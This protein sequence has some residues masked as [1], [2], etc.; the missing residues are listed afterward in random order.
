MDTAY[1]GRLGAAQL[2][3]AGV[4]L[5]M[6]NTA[7]KLFNVPLL[8][9]TTSNVAAAT[10]GA[11]AGRM[12]AGGGGG[13]AQAGAG[14]GQAEAVAA[15]ISSSL[16]VALLVG[17]L[18]VGGWS[19]TGTGTA[20]SEQVQTP[21]IVGASPAALACAAARRANPN[22]ESASLQ[23]GGIAGGPG[24]GHRPGGRAAVGGGTRLALARAYAAVSGHAGPGRPGNSHATGAAGEVWTR[25]ERDWRL[26]GLGSSAG[27]PVVLLAYSQDGRIHTDTTTRSSTR[28][29]RNPHVHAS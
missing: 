16:A 25:G 17:G 10:G 11:Q 28:T 4:A 24:V 27:T 21:G 7:S 12:Q 26:R 22:M 19:D 2:A 8:S 20:C 13:G 14:A 23:P 1:I 5:S 15:A 6:F 9:V 3:G 29:Q 18:Q